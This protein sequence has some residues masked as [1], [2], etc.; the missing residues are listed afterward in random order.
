MGLNEEKKLDLIRRLEQFHTDFVEYKRLV[1]QRG[2]Y[3]NAARYQELK[4]RLPRDFGGL[5]AVIREY[6]GTTEVV[7]MGG[8][9]HCDA[10]IAS[11]S[12]SPY[13]PQALNDILDTAISA[14]NIT[15]GKLQSLGSVEEMTIA[16]A[17]VPPNVFV[18]HGGE[19]EVLAKL[20]NFLEAL[21]MKSIVAEKEPSEG[22][23]V[24]KQVEWCLD[25][26]DCAIILATKGDIDNKTGD[27]IP[28][29]NVLI[30]VGR[31]QE[32]FPGKIVYLKET[33]TKF[34]SNISEKVW[35]HFTDQC[36]DK[37]FTKVA[38]ELRAFG[39]IKTVK[40]IKKKDSG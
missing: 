40:P 19:S 21:G 7:L 28:R 8:N 34:P 33:N 14:I 12:P 25:Q 29:G 16:E 27:F 39:I 38:K 32:R 5:E 36:M 17:S 3:P 35:E 24:D 11:F 31:V 9:Y 6:G 1:S 10:F 4:A 20:Q 2:R 37:A 13:D 15:I 26:S 22:R 30:E 23:S 18:A